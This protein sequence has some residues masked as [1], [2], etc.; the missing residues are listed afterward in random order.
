[1]KYCTYCGKELID[2]AAYCP[3]CGSPS[4]FRES[5]SALTPKKEFAWKAT[6]SM[7]LSLVGIFAFAIFTGVPA[8][9][10]ALIA[11]SENDGVFPIQAKVGFIIGIIDVA[12]G[13]IYAFL[14]QSSSWSLFW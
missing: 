1:M 11:K 8:I 2:S 13:C 4:N 6:L 7:V 10:L 3:Y 9:V 5:H 12:L 14:L